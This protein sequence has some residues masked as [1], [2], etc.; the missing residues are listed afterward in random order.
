MNRKKVLPPS[1]FD[2][3]GVIGIEEEFY[4]VDEETLSPVEKPTEFFESLPN[5]LENNLDVE[6]FD[7]VVEIRINKCE[8]I[9]RAKRELKRKRRILK[10]HAKEFDYKVLA[11]GLH[12]NMNWNLYEHSE[13]P[14]YINQ[15]KRIQYPQKRNT[16]AGLHVHVGMDD[17][18]KAVWIANEIRRYLPLFLALSANSPFW[19]AKDTGLESA[20]SVVFENLP[21]TGIP[22]YHQGIKEYRELLVKFLKEGFIEQVGEIWWDVRINN[23]YGSIEIRAP[24]TQIDVEK[25][26]SIV[27]LVSKIVDE[28]ASRYDEGKTSSSLKQEEVVANKWQ[29]TRYGKDAEFLIDGKKIEVNEFLNKVINKTDLVEKQ[30]RALREKT[31]SEIQRNTHRREG[32]RGVLEEIMI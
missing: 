1:L 19:Q 30:V 25:T 14:N 15:L 5:S 23:K 21:N 8:T 31:G 7:F 4:L 29:A 12:P 24:D 32:M 27:N 16:T 3:Y 17:G 2:E 9:E 6:L 22:S 18:D 28:L 20:R 13:K 11:A 26:Y 10:R